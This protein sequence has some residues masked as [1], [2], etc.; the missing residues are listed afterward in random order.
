[1][2]LKIRLSGQFQHALR[3]GGLLELGSVMR[4]ETQNMAL[5]GLQYV[6]LRT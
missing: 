1:M 3:G 5:R 2:Q 4:W 6:R